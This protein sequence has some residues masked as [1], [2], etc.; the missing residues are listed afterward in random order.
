[1]EW[2]MEAEEETTRLPFVQA[3]KKNPIVSSLLH[4][5]TQIYETLIWSDFSQFASYVIPNFT[6]ITLAYE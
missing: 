4:T 6:F 5:Y 2:L 3:K 1:M